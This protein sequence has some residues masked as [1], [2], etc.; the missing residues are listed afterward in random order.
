MLN[1]E[2]SICYACVHWAHTP[3]TACRDILGMN[4]LFQIPEG[5]FVKRISPLQTVIANSLTSSTKMYLMTT[6]L[7]LVFFFFPPPSQ[8]DTATKATSCLCGIHWGKPVNMKE[9]GLCL[10]L[11]PW[12]LKSEAMFSLGSLFPWNALILNLRIER[13][14]LLIILVTAACSQGITMSTSCTRSFEM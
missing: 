4:S 13:R 6:C 1:S 10:Q 5:G 11:R 12:G 3:W 8:Q 14:R 9:T 7:L 2:P